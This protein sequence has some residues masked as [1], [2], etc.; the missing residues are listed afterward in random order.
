MSTHNFLSRDLVRVCLFGKCGRKRWRS[1]DFPTQ[2]RKFNRE[3][4]RM[5]ENEFPKEIAQSIIPNNFARI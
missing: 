5:Y 1:G 3:R 4:W 2:M